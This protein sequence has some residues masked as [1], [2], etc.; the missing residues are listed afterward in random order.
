MKKKEFVKS[1]LRNLVYLYLYIYMYMYMYILFFKRQKTT[2]SVKKI[3]L[4]TWY[5]KQP[6]GYLVLNH[7]SINMYLN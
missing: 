2:I 7:I 5:T 4:R 6:F 3:F 1:A